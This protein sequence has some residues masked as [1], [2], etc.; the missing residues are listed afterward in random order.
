M[1][2]F[3]AELGKEYTVCA[4]ETEDGYYSFCFEDVG[5]IKKVCYRDNKKEH[6]LSFNKE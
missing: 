6:S 3:E 2:L 4:L 5:E 1:T